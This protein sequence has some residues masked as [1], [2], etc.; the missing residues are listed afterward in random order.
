MHISPINNNYKARKNYSKDIS[1]KMKYPMIKTKNVDLGFVKSIE[2]SLDSL[3]DKW[4]EILSKNNYK[5]YC[6]NTIQDTYDHL[7]LWDTAPNWDAITCGHPLFSFFSF[8]PQI[9]KNDIKKVV[10]HEIS[11]G[12][13]NSENLTEKITIMESLGVD[14]Q[15]FPTENLG[16]TPFDI[17]HLRC[18]FLDNYRVNEVLADIL[19]WMQDG[20]GLWGSGYKGG[21]KEPDFLRM[22]FPRTFKWLSNYP[23]GEPHKYDDMPF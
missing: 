3:P 21:T 12:I 7:N 4:A 6:S 14:I 20:G 1:F 5:L 23:I 8:T 9:G 19:A 11:H 13:V 22:N 2:N 18:R 17:R 10:N 15:K 16:E